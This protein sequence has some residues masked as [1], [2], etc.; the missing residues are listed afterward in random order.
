M[1]ETTLKSVVVL[2][3]ETRMFKPAA[4]NLAAPEA[5]DLV[6]TFSTEGRTA[7]VID[8]EH[9]HRSA[10]PLKCKFC[11]LAAEHV[12]AHVAS[13]TEDANREAAS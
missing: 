8:Q 10:D 1:T 6:Q 2:D 9:R 4:H 3:P 12:S 13:P 7:R 5:V 11:A